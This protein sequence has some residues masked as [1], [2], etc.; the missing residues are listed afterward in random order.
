MLLQKK[1]LQIID[2]KFSYGPAMQSGGLQSPPAPAFGSSEIGMSGKASSQWVDWPVVPWAA[3]ENEPVSEHNWM[4]TILIFLTQQA[5]FL[6]LVEVLFHV[7]VAAEWP[8][9]RV[10]VVIHEPWARLSVTSLS[11]VGWVLADEVVVH[12]QLMPDL[13]RHDLW[14]TQLKFMWSSFAW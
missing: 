7:I 14:K 9:V 12:T 1:L 4:V 2:F 10:F 8:L 13:V 11:R 5:Y 6:Q 3:G